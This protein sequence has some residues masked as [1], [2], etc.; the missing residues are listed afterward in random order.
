MPTI[1]K[2]SR[3]KLSFSPSSDC[4][5]DC[6]AP[7]VYCGVESALAGSYYPNPTPSPVVSIGSCLLSCP[8]KHKIAADLQLNSYSGF[9]YG[10]ELSFNNGGFSW[11]NVNTQI[12]SSK[13]PMSGALG[14]L[15]TLNSHNTCTLAPSSSDP[16]LNDTSSGRILPSGCGSSF[17]MSYPND[18]VYKGDL[19]IVA[20]GTTSSSATFTVSDPTGSGGQGNTWSSAVSQCTNDCVK[21]FYAVAKRLKRRHCDDYDDSIGGIHVRLHPRIRWTERI[22]R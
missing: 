8:F 2:L 16:N 14:A 1:S 9:S 19:L 20:V 10:W 5:Y 6:A 15:Q 22:S 12:G 4:G 18:W 7:F 21:V 17:T 11:N 13:N 3:N